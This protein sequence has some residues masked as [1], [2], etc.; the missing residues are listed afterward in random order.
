MKRKL[1]MIPTGGKSPQEIN[2]AA[3]AAL[4]KLLQAKK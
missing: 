4:L 2:Q 1:F 3:K